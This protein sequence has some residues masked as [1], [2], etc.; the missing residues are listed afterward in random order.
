MSLTERETFE[1]IGE[2]FWSNELSNWH[3]GREG[4]VA[5]KTKEC[6]NII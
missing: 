4:I 1:C 6:H 5:V 3:V 2:W